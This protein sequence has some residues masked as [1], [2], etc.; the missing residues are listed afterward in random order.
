[1][2]AAPGGTSYIAEIKGMIRV[3]AAGTLLLQFAQNAASGTSSVLADSHFVV[4][5]MT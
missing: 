3:N 2:G 1:V 4:E 5:Q